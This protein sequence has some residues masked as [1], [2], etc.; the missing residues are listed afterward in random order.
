VHPPLRSLSAD[1]RA[2]FVRLIAYL[3]G[4][5]ALAVLTAEVVRTR[6]VVAAIERTVQPEWIEVSRPAPAFELPSPG[7]AEGEAGYAIRRHV[8]GGG[9]KDIMTWGEAGR[10]TRYAM[11]EIYRPGGEIA[12]FADPA[13]EIAARAAG[14]GPAGA[15]KI[16]LPIASKFGPLAAVEFSIGRFAV[17][18]CIG[19]VRNF[20][21]PRLQISG[22]VC[23]MDS[24]VDRAAIACALDRFTLLSAGGDARVA[25]LFARAEVKRTFCGQRD[26]LFYATPKREYHATPAPLKLRGR[27]SAR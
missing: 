7:L 8:A 22:L 1:L 16:S 9:R 25:E 23:S 21:A 2:T 18:H 4:I 11:L 20:A 27:L 24:I 10:S 13:S 14:L 3:C 19:F 26:P 15:V 12:R 17:G 5:A 6:P